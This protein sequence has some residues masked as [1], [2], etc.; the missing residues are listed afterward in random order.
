MTLIW[1]GG[2]V[3]HSQCRKL[4]LQGHVALE[5]H[6]FIISPSS[7]ACQQRKRLHN[8]YINSVKKLQRVF[9][10]RFS[11]GKMQ[12]GVFLTTHIL[13][14]MRVYGKAAGKLKQEMALLLLCTGVVFA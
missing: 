10:W 13:H 12:A 5:S 6:G 9:S 11:I 4:L 2:W 14:T 7:K 3:T 1:I 8:D